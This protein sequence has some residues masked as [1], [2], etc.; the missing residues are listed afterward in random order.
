MKPGTNFERT[1]ATIMPAAAGFSILVY[2][3][4]EADYLRFPVIS[5]LVEEGAA[6][7]AICVGKTFEVRPAGLGLHSPP[8]GHDTVLEGP[9]GDVYDPRLP[10]HQWTNAGEWLFAEFGAGSREG[11]DE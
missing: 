7:M 2:R 9:T 4:S 8:K 10:T 3:K 5:W 1:R 11:A 6:A